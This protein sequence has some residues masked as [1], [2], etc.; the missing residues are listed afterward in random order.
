MIIVLYAVIW[1]AIAT[2]TLALALQR[3]GRARHTGFV[4]FL[5][6]C[7]VPFLIIGWSLAY[8]FMPEM[9][10]FY[11]QG[12]VYFFCAYIPMA[13]IS[14][15][16]YM[17]GATNQKGL[18]V[19]FPLVVFILTVFVISSPV[20]HASKYADLLEVEEVI[21]FNEA[22]IFLDQEEARFV[23]MGLAY[24]SASELLGEELGV[25]SRYSIG[26]MR[27]QNVT[28]DLRW[29]APFEH[30]TFLRWLDNSTVPGYVDVSVKNY[31]DA[32]M[33]LEGADI[34]YGVDG[35][36]FSSYLPRHLYLNGYSDALL[37]DFTFEINDENKPTWV[38]TI[39]EPKVG[40]GG[41]VPAGVLV[42]D[43]ESGK[44]SEYP[45]DKTPSWV[46]RIQPL[47]NVVERIQDWGQYQDGFI[48][49]AFIGD[50]VIAPSYGTSF[51]FDKDGNGVWYTGIQSKGSQQEGTM[52]FML[53]DSRTGTAKFYRRA[54]ITEI[55][56]KRAIE[57][58]VQEAGYYASYPIPYQISGV[59]TYLS[60]LKDRSGNPQGIGLAAYN[61]RS[62]VATGENMEIALRR[63][64]SVLSSN[65]ATVQTLDIE[66][67]LIRLEGMVKRSV[68]QNSDNRTMLH[69]MLSGSNHDD[70][71]YTVAADG[72]KEALHT[73]DNDQVS[74]EV[75]SLKHKNVNVI[76]F[77]NLEFE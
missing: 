15:F 25:G 16:G 30:K 26:A 36:Y 24:R 37:D 18:P 34:N 6:I 63:Y 38:V 31:K 35:F 69:F 62:M 32:T 17:E 66:H 3:M 11:Y 58:R 40:F 48:N 56:A 77:D 68:L 50:K 7:L 55:A 73:Q 41:K 72:N 19:I 54:G 12:Y 44:I 45:I 1:A 59:S 46:D 2:T 9:G 65:G 74:M 29:V 28:G 53:V 57:G 71:F 47:E 61:N 49:G 52:G 42:V 39:M 33:K 27:I 22:D 51:V 60:I 43:A 13:V 67:E 4:P 76:R 75:G 64:L 20:L 21:E 23:D 70:K 10:L 5:L 8:F 14:W